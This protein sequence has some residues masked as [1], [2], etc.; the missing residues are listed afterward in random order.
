[1]RVARCS[2]SCFNNLDHGLTG[3]K[4]LLLQLGVCVCGGVEDHACQY[5]SQKGGTHTHYLLGTH[6]CSKTSSTVMQLVPFGYS[7]GSATDVQKWASPV[8]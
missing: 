4:Y 5:P 7:Y 3:G 6:T 2:R 8:M 1:M